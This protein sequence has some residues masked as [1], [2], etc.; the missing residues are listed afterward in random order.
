M[1]V[2]EQLARRLAATLVAGEWNSSSLL[3]R[4]KALLGRST[5]TSQRLLIGDLLT[6]HPR[7]Y[8]PPRDWVVEFL[9]QSRRFERISN[10][11]SV[12]IALL[13]SSLASPSFKPIARLAGL[14]VPKLI[15][16]GKLA[17]WLGVTTNQLEWFAD[18]TK[19][20]SHSHGLGLQHYCHAFIPRKSGPPRL[21]ESPKP[22]LKALQ[23]CIL[24]DILDAVPV[25]PCAHGFVANR[26]CLSAAQA[27]AA[28]SL[29]VTLDLKDFFLSTPLHRVYGIFRSIGYPWRVAR[30]L[31]GLCT[32]A[33]PPEVIMDPDMRVQRSWAARKAYEAP[34]LPQGAPTSPALSNLVARR[35]DARLLGLAKSCEANY[36]RYADDLIFSGS[37]SFVSGIHRFLFAVEA[38]VEDEGYAVN[39]RKTRVMRRCGAQRITGLIVN[40]HLNVSRASYDILKATLHNCIRRGPRAENRS[41]ARGFR[42]HLEGRV[43]WVENVNPPR[44]ARLRSMFNQVQW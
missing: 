9:L 30:L 40:D 8:P 23:L 18:T 13:R 15:V 28:E 42:A 24:R 4:S 11:R 3:H 38:I 7:I 33:T 43:V 32:T 17:A 41:G 16:P 10:S 6:I 35:L 2:R 31:T 34:H 19:R 26:S 25:H 29:V 36:T 14:D 1:N 12:S 22:R 37:E 5:L 20:R 44:G 39:H 21:I 27:H